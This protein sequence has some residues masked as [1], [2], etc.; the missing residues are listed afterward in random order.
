[1]GVPFMI[2]AATRF[3]VILVMLVDHESPACRA[4]RKD[5]TTQVMSMCNVLGVL[6]FIVAFVIYPGHYSYA[7]YEASSDYSKPGAT[8]LTEGVRVV[9]R[10][11]NLL[12]SA[13]ILRYVR[14]NMAYVVV[15]FRAMDIAMSLLLVH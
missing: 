4:F 14:V 1:M 12:Q 8:H 5:R 10:L 3:L 9:L 7:A 13:H 11:L 2:D 6:S 15:C